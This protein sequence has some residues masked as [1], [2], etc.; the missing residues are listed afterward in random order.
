M[1]T[2]AKLTSPI[3]Y[4]VVTYLLTHPTTTQL[5]TSRQAGVSIGWVNAVI[6]TLEDNHV[7]RRGK[8]SRLEL[9]DPIS[10]LDALAWERPLSRLRKTATPL[11]ISNPQEAET[12][13]AEI[14]LKSKTRYALTGFA[15]LSRY[16]AY[17]IGYP[18]IHAYAAENLIAESLPKGRGAV[19]IELFNPDYPSIFGHAQSHD[20]F[21]VVEPIQVVIDLY[22]LGS[23]GRDAAMK[24]YELTVL[25]SAKTNPR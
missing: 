16:L 8:K 21:S 12:A 3:A 9:V 17:H 15:G 1:K 10:L 6:K 19:T 18:T 7:I 5:E 20:G 4:Q 13:L 25:E 24:L 2:A 11:E 22:C 14:C 23:A